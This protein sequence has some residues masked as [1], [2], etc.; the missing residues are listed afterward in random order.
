MSDVTDGVGTEVEIET[1]YFL[2]VALMSTGLII[3]FLAIILLFVSGFSE[4][5]K[6][7]GEVKG[8]GAVI[9]GPFPV[10]F[11][12]DRDSIKTVL[13]LAIILTVILTT[14]TVL[15]YLLSR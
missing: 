4:N 2:G 7:K 12:T 1:L 14:A 3:T 9:I 13:L 6:G 8:G 11:G 15:F 5:R 10:V